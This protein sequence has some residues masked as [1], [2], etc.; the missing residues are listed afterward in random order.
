MI[1]AGVDHLADGVEHRSG[2]WSAG[3]CGGDV[4]LGHGR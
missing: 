4:V 1:D 2:V 3:E